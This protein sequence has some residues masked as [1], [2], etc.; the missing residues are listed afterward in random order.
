MPEYYQIAGLFRTKKNRKMTMLQVKSLILEIELLES[1][2]YSS[3]MFISNLIGSIE[4]T[5]HHTLGFDIQAK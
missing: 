5:A 4:N 1:P 3:V 2:G